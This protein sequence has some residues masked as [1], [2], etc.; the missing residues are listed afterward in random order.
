M[1]NSVQYRVTQ[2]DPISGVTT[3]LTFAALVLE[4]HRMLALHPVT[5]CVG[6]GPHAVRLCLALCSPRSWYVAHLSPL[7]A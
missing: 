5:W 2:M 4:P 6:V 1:R 3:L 7:A